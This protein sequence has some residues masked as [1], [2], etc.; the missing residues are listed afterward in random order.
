MLLRVSYRTALDSEL[1][2]SMVAQLAKY[3]L[4]MRGQ[5]PWCVADTK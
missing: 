5:I 2:A 3:L 1:R 4:F